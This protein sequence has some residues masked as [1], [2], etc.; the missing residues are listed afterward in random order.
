MDRKPVSPEPAAV[1]YSQRVDDELRELL[2]HPDPHSALERVDILIARASL[3]DA[4]SREATHALEVKAVLLSRIDDDDTSALLWQQVRRQWLVLEG[5][6]SPRAAQAQRQRAMT[7][8]WAHDVVASDAE[9]TAYLT[10]AERLWG[11][12]ADE[13]LDGMRFRVGILARLGR[14]DEAIA[15]QRT[16]LARAVQE[17]G[18]DDVRVLTYRKDL[19]VM[20]RSHSGAADALA[21]FSALLPDAERVHG[22]WHAESLDVREEIAFTLGRLERA[23]EA[24]AAYRSLID[25]LIAGDDTAAL[26]TA[27]R[28][29][30]RVHE[31][32]VDDARTDAALRDATATLAAAL[33]PAHPAA[34]EMR[35]KWAHRLGETRREDEAIAEHEALITALQNIGGDPDLDEDDESVHDAL[36]LAEHAIAVL[37]RRLG[38]AEPA[39]ARLQRALG[40]EPAPG[41]RRMLLQAMAMTLTDLG[42]GDE[43]IAIM[44]DLAD[45]GS[46]S[47]RNDLAVAYIRDDRFREALAVLEGVRAE[48]LASDTTTALRVLGNIALASCELGRH[49]TALTGWAGLL[50][51]QRARLDENDADLLRTR[52]NLAR[53]YHHLGDHSRS[54]STYD[55]V[56]SD[57]VRV[58]GPENPLTL[59]SMSGRAAVALAAGDAVDAARR[60]R[61]VL[62]VRARVLG[63]SHPLTIDTADSLAAAEERLGNADAARAVRDASLEA[64]SPT[65]AKDP[66]SSARA[67]FRRA[68]LLAERDRRAEALVEFSRAADAFDSALGPAHPDAVRARLGVADSMHALQRSTEAVSAYRAVLAFVPRLDDARLH[69]QTL[70]HLSGALLR[71]AKIGDGTPAG[72]A[73]DE[74]VQLQRQAIEIASAGA[75]ADDP[76][77]LTLRSRLGRRLGMMHRYTDAEAVYRAV[78]ADRARVLGPDHR[79]T[80]DSRSDI[81]ETLLARGRN[82]RATREFSRLLPVMRRVTGADSPDTR[83]AERMQSRAAKPAGRQIAGVVLAAAFAAAAV[84]W[85]LTE[86]LV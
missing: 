2:A 20:T 31:L 30:V 70:D 22:A 9:M 15:L 4:G 77:T 26:V 49:D 51:A 79:D 24:D 57:R 37:E 46:L 42:R 5:D 10:T 3:D 36:L 38:R 19:A 75:G 82:I 63:P 14:D 32:N 28:R 21:Q 58:H 11:A 25:V 45:G 74:A 12:G 68:E 16:V 44:R 72:P 86:F 29:R 67:M 53:E 64:L 18:P 39:R 7:L 60:F 61:E 83:R 17:H 56:I 84:V 6:D 81:A 55:L 33:G 66:I 76:Y 69:A 65:G 48:A 85:G 13:T 8:Y 54:I 62:D 34:R 1:G 78:A 59:S 71:T 43:A 47:E 23:D 40:M 41:A 80:L 27:F 50:A 52:H 73:A 35:E